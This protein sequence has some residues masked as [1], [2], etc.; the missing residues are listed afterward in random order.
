MLYIDRDPLH[1]LR[2]PQLS[3]I[4]IENSEAKKKSKF[5]LKV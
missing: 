4:V 1:E 2:I 3:K 5:K